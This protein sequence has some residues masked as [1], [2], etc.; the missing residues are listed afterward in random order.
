M[1]TD[2]F[3]V[4]CANAGYGTFSPGA[5][6]EYGAKTTNNSVI[7]PASTCGLVRSVYVWDTA[8]NIVEVGW[9]EDGTNGSA[10]KC[11]DVLSPHILV[12]AI[13]NGF[14]KCKTGTNALSAGQSYS[15]RVDNPDHDFDFVYY[16]DDDTTPNIS[17]GFYATDHR[18]GFPQS[19]DER[20]HPNDSLRASFSGLNSLGGGGAWHAFPSP[21]NLGSTGNVSGFTV[22]SWGSTFLHVRATGNC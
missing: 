11:S 9:F 10:A 21:V 15:F 1:P 7:N 19:G 16:W 20:K 22:C 12:Y 6:N 8:D 5:T 2:A 3:A 4:T 18:N 13:V 14:I 17:L